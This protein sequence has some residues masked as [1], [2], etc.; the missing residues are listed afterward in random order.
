MGERIAYYRVSTKD[1]DIASQR[2][3]LGGPF[4][5][6]FTD[7]GISGATQAADRPGFAAMFKY[8]RAG[9]TIFVTAIDRL[10]RDAIDVQQTVRQLIDKGV[11]V[12]VKGLGTITK[13]PGEIVLAVLAQVA[14]MERDRIAERTAAGRATAR[15]SLAST[16]RTHRGK[17]SL[18]RPVKTSPDAIRTWRTENTAS[19]ADT[20]AHFDI[21]IATVKRACTTKKPVAPLEKNDE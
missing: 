3:A 5:N 4:D 6:E 9:D 15:E 12:D 21:S 17:E 20:A 11:T 13:G 19:I 10:G 2:H 1:Q 14:S 16:G 18:G 8:A 7:E